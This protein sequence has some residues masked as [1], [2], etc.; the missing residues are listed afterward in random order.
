MAPWGHQ[1]AAAG[2]VAQVTVAVGL[3]LLVAVVGLVVWFAAQTNAKVA[4]A[5]RML[6]GIGAFVA[7]LV[8]AYH[9]VR[10]P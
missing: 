10:L 7:L 1:P 4:E 3:P 2:A 9:V 8:A 5:G 6:F